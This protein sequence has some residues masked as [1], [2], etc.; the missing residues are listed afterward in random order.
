MK[1]AMIYNGL[2]VTNFGD[3]TLTVTLTAM[4]SGGAHSSVDITLGPKQK[5][6]GVHYQWFPDIDYNDL[7]WIKATTSSPDLAGIAIT[8]NWNGSLI[9]FTQGLVLE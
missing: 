6:I 8:N 7:T 4:V 3:T 5:T 9:V 1:D 2:A